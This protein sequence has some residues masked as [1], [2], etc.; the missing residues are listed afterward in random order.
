MSNDIYHYEP[1]YGNKGGFQ[2]NERV[3]AV[4]KLT[5]FIHKTYR[6]AEG[7]EPGKPVWSYVERGGKLT[8]IESAESAE[9]VRAK[10]EG[11][12]SEKP[13]TKKIGAI[14]RLFFGLHQQDGK[15]VEKE[16]VLQ[17]VASRFPTFTVIEST[18]YYKG[19][20]EPTLI[21]E[22]A[23][24]GGPQME[25]LARDLADAFDQDAVGIE[26]G[27][28]YTRVFGEKK[29]ETARL[30][31]EDRAKLNQFTGALGDGKSF[32]ELDAELQAWWL[33]RY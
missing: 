20:P 15:V 12:P 33:N 25:A 2:L 30:V 28:I 17:M 22:I 11:K 16:T 3:Q 8:E 13:A 24:P 10:L 31:E 29:R 6:N 19:Q 23:A 18:G 21:I 4:Y 26:T 27:G 1:A 7:Q 32:D 9:A 14:R 5:G